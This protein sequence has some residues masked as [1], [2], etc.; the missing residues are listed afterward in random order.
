MVGTGAGVQD[1]FPS[2]TEDDY[3]S[4]SHTSVKRPAAIVNGTVPEH[5]PLSDGELVRWA[6]S[7][8]KRS[9]TIWDAGSGQLLGSDAL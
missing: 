2:V 1:A 3:S 4:G 7:T 9:L 6:T 5:P 8:S